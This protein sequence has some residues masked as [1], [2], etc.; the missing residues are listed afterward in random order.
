MGPGRTLD[1]DDDD[2]EDDDVDAVAGDWE[3]TEDFADGR[4]LAFLSS[5]GYTTQT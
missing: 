5:C 1:D 3:D 2:D 4:Y